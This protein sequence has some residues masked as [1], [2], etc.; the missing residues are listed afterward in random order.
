[1]EQGLHALQVGSRRAGDSSWRIVQDYLLEVLDTLGV[2][3]LLSEELTSLPGVDEVAALLE[4]R[5]RAESGQWDLVVVDCAPTAETLRLL[6]LPEA[7][8]WHLERV[9]PAQPGL[10]RTLRPAAAAA[11]GIPLP[12][13]EVAR[14]LTAWYRQMRDVHAMLTGPLASIRLVLTPERVVV[15]EARRMW[16]SLSLY[17]FAVDG[18]VVNRVVPDAVPGQANTRGADPWLRSWNEAQQ[19]ALVEVEESFTGLPVVRV[20]YLPRE[21]IGGE[22]LDSLA[23][24]LAGDGDDADPFGVRSPVRDRGLTVRRA[25]TGYLLTLPLPLVRAGDVDL[26]RREDELLLTVGDHRRVLSLPSVLRR[27]IVRDARVEEG[28][29][30]VAF[31]PDPSLWPAALDAVPEPEADQEPLATP[32]TAR[33][34]KARSRESAHG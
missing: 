15:A 12:S 4:L 9:L 1:V 3:P 18:L 24:S 10:L 20:P 22:A 11:A 8:A 6:V 14:T 19:A 17:G 29:L 31:E 25:N 7:L 26:K 23:A 2:D 28:A 34:R 33:H 16:T 13:A 5:A 32:R 21:P 27:C 30:Q